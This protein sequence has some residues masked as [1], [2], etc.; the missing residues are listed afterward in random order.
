MTEEDKNDYYD[1]INKNINRLL[2]YSNCKAS[3]EFNIKIARFKYEG[4]EYIEKIE[5][6]DHQRRY[7]HILATESINKINRLAKQYGIIIF[8]YNDCK[9]RELISN[10]E[11]NLKQKA[12]ADR[13]IAE[14]IIENFRTELIQNNGKPEFTLDELLIKKIYNNSENIKMGSCNPEIC[15]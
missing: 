13:K 9:N 3:M 12:L 8:E 6:M 10:D 7:K 4:E 2:D 15:I 5:E 1:F 14:N 11:N